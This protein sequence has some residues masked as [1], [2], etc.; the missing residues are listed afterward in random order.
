METSSLSFSERISPFLG[1]CLIV[2]FYGVAARYILINWSGVAS[3]LASHHVP[4]PS[5]VMIVA[6]AMITWGCFSLLFGYHPRYGAVILFSLTIVATVT[7]H[8]FWRIDD[9][10]A[11]QAEFGMFARNL[12]ICGGL[13]VII[14]LGCGPFGIHNR[15]PGGDDT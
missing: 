9:P 7:L 14:G 5:L 12:A 8:A 1:R 4:L 13:L 11:R 10:V 6:L 3:Q 2:W 15:G